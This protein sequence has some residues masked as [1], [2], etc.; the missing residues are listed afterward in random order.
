MADKKV[1]AL[2]DL[3]TGIAGED[4]LHV[5]DDPSGTPVNKKVSVSNVLNNLPDYLG[6]AQ[7][8]EAVSFSSNA[9][10]ATAGKWA[11][12]L[13]SSSSGQDVL[14]LGNGSTGQIKYFVLVSD[15]GSSPRVTPSGTFTGG[16]NVELDTAGDSV[17]M[18]YTGSTYGW[19]V[20]GGNGY[21]V[22]A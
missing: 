13:T 15:G 12:Y 17:V 3:G 2:S 7:S 14:T 1:T 18:L 16:S 20:I 10:T 5:I 11:H 6:F 21:S 22:N 9:A 4:L 8:A 19:V